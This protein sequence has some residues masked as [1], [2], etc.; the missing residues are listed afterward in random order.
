MSLSPFVTYGLCY[1][2]QKNRKGATNKTKAEVT[3]Y[4]INMSLN[5]FD[6]FSNGKVIVILVKVRIQRLPQSS[7]SCVI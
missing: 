2:N 6:L 1:Q 7:K 4:Q 3:A 5:E